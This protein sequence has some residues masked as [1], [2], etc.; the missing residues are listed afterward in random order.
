MGYI[1]VAHR[2]ILRQLDSISYF[3]N[4]WD[5]FVKDQAIHHNLIIKSSKNQCYCTNCHTTFIS[6]KKVNEEMKCPNC[7]NKYLIKRSNLKHYKF[8]DY[9]SILDKAN[10]TLVV[11]YFELR[12]IIDAFHNRTSSIVEFAREIPDKTRNRAVYV[13]ERVSRCQC[14]IYIHHSDYFDS[15]KWREYT[16]NYSI[17]D[18]SIVFPNNI[19]NILKNT[20]LRYS[21]IWNVVKH[22]PFYID[23]AKLIQNTSEIPKVEMLTK[24][25][26]YK[27]ALNDYWC[28]PKGSFQSIFGVPKT[29]YPFMKRN[30]ITYR[31]LKILRLLQEP[32]IKKIHYLET[33]ASYYNDEIDTFEEISKY[34]RLDRFIQYS[35][36]KHHKIDIHIYKDYL[37]FA[38][39]LGLDLKNNRYAFPKNLKESHDELEKQ[40]EI[41]NKK[42]INLAIVKRS[43]E[44]SKN[45]F[46]DGK[47]IVLPAT[48]IKDLQNESSQ[49]NNCVRTY[50]EKYAEGFCDIY[51]MRNAKK[52][53]KSLV[54]VE[55]RHN[56]VVQSRI[57]NNKCPT[58]Q[59]LQFLKSL[60]QNVLKG[61]A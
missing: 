2:K 16:R 21:E 38:K 35:K 60:E 27:L 20:P 46:N 55:V 7:N 45:T 50:A 54:T 42:I 40:Y 6:T 24:L 3:P 17:I 23:L 15:K 26:L 41:N 49:Q 28:N 53:G 44:L 57:K 14:Y 11:R 52:P 36:M 39:L 47:F 56:K 43:N 9:L 48:S 13:N 51:F 32:N 33:F 58:D 59:Q 31:Q 4:G 22:S 29:F 19:K 12:T 61:A 10:D 18:Y 37:R 30:N 25:K 34:I 1:T 8:K 5:K